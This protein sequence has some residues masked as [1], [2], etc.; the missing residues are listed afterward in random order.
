ME[1]FHRNDESS[2][3]RIHF[4]EFYRSLIGLS[5]TSSEKTILEITRSDI[6]YHTSKDASQW[7]DELLRRHRIME[8]LR[9]DC[10]DN[11]RIGPTM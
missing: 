10:F 11:L 1:S 3:P 7:I 6:C 9:L 8:E 4:S 5:T 2:F